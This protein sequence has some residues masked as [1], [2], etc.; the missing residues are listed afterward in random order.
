MTTMTRQFTQAEQDRRETHLIERVEEDC[1]GCKSKV[2]DEGYENWTP[3]EFCPVHGAHPE[4]WWKQ[5]N[6]E[7]D[8]LAP[9][10]WRES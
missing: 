6:D 8:A 10:T 5:L 2:D 3:A 1:A 7:L 9:G 4:S